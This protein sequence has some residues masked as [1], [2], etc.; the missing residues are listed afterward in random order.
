[1]G[2]EAISKSTVKN[3]VPVTEGSIGGVGDI[4][5]SKLLSVIK[6]IS[7][8]V[9]IETASDDV[10]SE[11]TPDDASVDGNSVPLTVLDSTDDVK[12]SNCIVEGNSI[13]RV[14][15]E[16]P[17]DGVLVACTFIDSTELNCITVAFE[18]GNKVSTTVDSVEL[19]TVI[20][21]LMVLISTEVTSTLLMLS[22]ME[23]TVISKLLWILLDINP[24]DCII[25]VDVV[26][27]ISST[28][29]SSLDNIVELVIG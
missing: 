3:D 28:V 26:I 10:I 18:A 21:L 27:V 5:G 29:T 6:F 1:M 25:R 24:V 9:M 11:R 14:T 13:V 17:M 16:F 20:K 2:V 4:I 15:L 12:V 7:L 8:L 19:I 22:A 23:I